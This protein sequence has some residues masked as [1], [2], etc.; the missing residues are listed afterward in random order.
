MLECKPYEL[1]GED[2]ILM[3]SILM[4]EFEPDFLVQG[5][6]LHDDGEGTFMGKAGRHEVQIFPSICSPNLEGETQVLVV[7][8]A[9]ST[10]QF[11]PGDILMAGSDDLLDRA[12]QALDEMEQ[13]GVVVGLSP[14]EDPS[15]VYV[16][17]EELAEKIQEW[18]EQKVPFLGLFIVEPLDSEAQ[19]KLVNLVRKVMN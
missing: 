15:Q 18:K 6:G 2:I 1:E 10:S 14:T 8:L 12:F 11:R 13:R 3:K 16:S 7:G 5:L 9:E 4:T 17:K 19:A